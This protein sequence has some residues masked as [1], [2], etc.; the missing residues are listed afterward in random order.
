[1]EKGN[2]NHW[3]KG[4]DQP[5]LAKNERRE[6]KERKDFSDKGRGTPI[7]RSKEREKKKGKNPPRPTSSYTIKERQGTTT[8]VRGN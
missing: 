4:P 7:T 2:P 8:T 3:G 1:L 5:L 6:K